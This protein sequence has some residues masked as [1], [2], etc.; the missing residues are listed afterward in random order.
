MKTILLLL[1]FGILSQSCAPS[2]AISLVNNPKIAQSVVPSVKKAIILQRQI[3]EAASTSQINITA[4]DADIT[5][6]LEYAVMIKS[7]TDVDNYGASLHAGLIRSL[8]SADTH[9]ELL[10][11]ANTALIANDMS[12]QT[13]LDQALVYSQ[14]KD[15]ESEQWVK[16][17]KYK[18]N[19]IADLTDKLEKAVEQETALR[20]KLEDAGVY[21][22]AVFALVAL[23]F[24]FFVFKAVVFGWSPFGKF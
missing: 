3:K 16:T 21:K 2:H 12:M 7:Y 8:N 19:V 14:N 6:S 20:L 10:M 1:A 24:A 4:V 23:I 22:K 15:L 18:D 9:I 11:L 5:K 17:S 13:I